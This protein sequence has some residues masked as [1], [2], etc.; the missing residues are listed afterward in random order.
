MTTVVSEFEGTLLKDPDPFSYFMLVAFE[1][2]GIIRFALLLLMWPVI[3]VLEALGQG[4]A[5]LRLIIF[6]AVSGVRMSEIESV[7]RAVLPKFYMDDVNMDAWKV[8]SSYGKRVVITKTPRIMVEWFV[9]DHLLADEVV[10]SE[11]VVNRF[12]YATG[13]IKG[14]MSVISNQ[15]AQVL[16]SEDQP[17]IVGLRRPEPGC[18][19]PPCKETLY[20]P[21]T[22]KARLDRQDLRPLP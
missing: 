18:C 21:Y 6:V 20:P 15:A 5:G 16:S 10:G 1:A 11:L 17:I 19:L 13:F 4:D 12:G 14:E 7:A 8:F 3:R 2:S 22:S 9:R